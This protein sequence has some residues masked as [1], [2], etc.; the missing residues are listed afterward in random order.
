MLKIE[1]EGTDGAGKTTAL[2]YLL[3]KLQ[4]KGKRV[5]ETRDVG[6]PHIPACVKL[7]E[8]VLNPDSN[9]CGETMEFIFA[10]MRLENDKYYKTVA[11]DYDFILSDRGWLTHLAY[12]DHNVS[13]DFTNDFYLDI[14]EPLTDMPDVVIYLSVDGETA[15]QRRIRRGEE[16]DVIEL[17]G[18]EYQEL[19]R[20]SF[21]EYLMKYSGDTKVIIIDAT[22]DLENVQ[23]Q[24]DTT[25]NILL[26]LSN[27]QEEVLN[28]TNS[29]GNLSS[30]QE[31]TQAKS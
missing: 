5:L 23:K 13:K 10:G 19:V 31:E 22:K 2:K 9:L 3:N 11:E 29:R 27:N 1:V 4:L 6:C 21:Q 15:L 24:L 25:L 16:A 14:V 17:K 7:R 30:S 20:G 28:G 18:P 12:T 8:I 26:S